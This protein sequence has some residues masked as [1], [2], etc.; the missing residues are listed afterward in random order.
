MVCSERDN[1]GKLLGYILIIFVVI[2]VYFL[3]V[4]IEKF[5]M[6]LSGTNF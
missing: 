1:W 5:D 6:R 3:L 4:L 2:C